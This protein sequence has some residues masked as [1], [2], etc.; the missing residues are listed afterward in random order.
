MSPTHELLTHIPPPLIS[1]TLMGDAELGG[2]TVRVSMNLAL[3]AAILR[4]S[5][6]RYITV[7]EV[8]QM[9]GVSTR[10]AGKLLA[11]LESE[12]VVVRYSVRAYRVRHLDQAHKN[13]LKLQIRAASQTRVITR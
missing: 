2:D 13:S 11:K 10:T 7:R 12:G 9:L 3:I 6:K 1:L 8:S 5:G 4:G